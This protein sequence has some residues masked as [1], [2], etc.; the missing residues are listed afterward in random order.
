MRYSRPRC[1]SHA[2]TTVF[3]TGENVCACHV[4][5]FVS[6]VDGYTATYRDDSSPSAYGYVLVHSSLCKAVSI[7]SGSE[8]HLTFHLFPQSVADLQP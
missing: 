5:V 4:S 6:S 3:Y 8:Y 7:D 1:D 2:G